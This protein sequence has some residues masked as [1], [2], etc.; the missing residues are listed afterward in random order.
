M[1]GGGRRWKEV[2]GG[3]RRWEEVGGGERRWE[4][5]IGG[6]RMCKRGHINKT[7]GERQTPKEQ[8]R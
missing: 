8:L 3:E 7:R 2:R 1:G 6:K 4:K 5:V